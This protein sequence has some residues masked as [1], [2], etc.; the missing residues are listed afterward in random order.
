MEYC[1]GTNKFYINSKEIKNLPEEITQLVTKWR[2]YEKGIQKIFTK[3]MYDKEK[4]IWD[5]LMIEIPKM[6]QKTIEHIHIRI[7]DVE[8]KTVEVPCI[9]I[10]N[11]DIKISWLPANWEQ[12][13]R[14]IGQP[15]HMIN[16]DLRLIS[17]GCVML[18]GTWVRPS[19]FVK[20][21]KELL[22]E[23]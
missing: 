5:K 3:E 16:N 17:V 6:G 12:K 22:K 11:S 2:A 7:S 9:T 19:K 10:D 13:S 8:G 20:K 18:G 1:K 23:Q 21:L 14:L 15:I 4:A